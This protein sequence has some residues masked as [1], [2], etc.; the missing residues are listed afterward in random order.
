MNLN[1]IPVGAVVQWTDGVGFEHTET[2]HSFDGE[3]VVHT[4]HALGTRSHFLEL[5]RILNYQTSN[6]FKIISP[7]IMDKERIKANLRREMRDGNFHF[8]NF[9][10]FETISEK[11]ADDF[12]TQMVDRL[13]A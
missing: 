6:S 7:S 13:L 8:E 4:R 3:K 10:R 1:D 12:L 5:K 9:A 2:V 11:T